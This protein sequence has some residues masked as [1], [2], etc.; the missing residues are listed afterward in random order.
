MTYLRPAL[1]AN[2]IACFERQSYP[3]DRREL[4]V[5][6]DAGQYPTQPSGPG[7]RI[8]S[9]DRRF[10]TY[11]EKV[12]AAVG[13][14]DRDTDALILWDDDDAYASWHLETHARLIAEGADW[15]HPSAVYVEGGDGALSR[16]PTGGLFPASAAFSR[17][18]FVAVGGFPAENNGADQS[19]Y[20]RL[21]G[22]TG[23]RDPLRPGD[24]P[25][26]IYRWADTGS[27]HL[28]AMGAGGYDSPQMAKLAAAAEPVRDLRPKLARPWDEL[29][30]RSPRPRPVAAP[31]RRTKSPA[32]WS[33][34]IRDLGRLGFYKNFYQVNDRR[35]YR[36]VCIAKNGSSSLKEVLFRDLY[37]DRPLP[38][39]GL[40]GFFAA[41]EGEPL[42][43][44]PSPNPAGYVQFAV[45]RDPVE[46]LMSLYREKIGRPRTPL[47]YYRKLGLIGAPWD[48]FLNFVEAELAKPKS[49]RHGSAP[50]PAA[51]LLRPGAGRRRRRPIA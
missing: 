46:R 14:V 23:P 10:T 2:A 29:A 31:K 8:V 13:L 43:R 20:R 49:A 9:I 18:A 3:A 51:R 28:S 25:S 21:R 15:S 11:G 12:N 16:K 45:W 7:W 5:L 22:R 35:R 42:R 34:A 30:G 40:H 44:V 17:E 33:A 19:F 24:R 48:D 27:Y 39:G 1:L 41:G 38:A 32:E 36:A 50:P 26:Y 6:D 47:P 37:P 4:I